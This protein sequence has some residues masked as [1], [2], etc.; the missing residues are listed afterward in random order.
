[1]IYINISGIVEIADNI[2]VHLHRCKRWMI[3]FGWGVAR[4]FLNT[5]I[6]R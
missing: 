3:N 4:Y 2:H 5:L 1:M 6:T